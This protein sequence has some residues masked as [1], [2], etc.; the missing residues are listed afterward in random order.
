MKLEYS[1]NNSGGRW[2]LDDNDW[3]ALERV[4][5]TIDWYKD[6]DDGWGSYKDGRFLDALASGAHK[7][8]GSKTEATEAIEQFEKVTGQSVTDQ[9]CNCCGRPH[10]FTLYDDD[11]NYISAF[12]TNPKIVEY[13]KGWE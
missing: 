11:D 7:I 4:G 5:W 9:G 13:D 2:W 12:E 10:Y 3:Y 1:S 8:V 6:R